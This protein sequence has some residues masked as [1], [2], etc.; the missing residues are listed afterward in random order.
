MLNSRLHNQLL[1]MMSL[2]GT[3]LEMNTDEADNAGDDGAS[4][5]ANKCR[6]DGIAHNFDWIYAVIGYVIGSSLSGCV[7]IWW[8]VKQPNI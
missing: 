6:N 7:I 4:D 5:S 1:P 8:C 3:A 2:I